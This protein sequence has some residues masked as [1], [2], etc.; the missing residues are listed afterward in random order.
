MGRASNEGALALDSEGGI[1]VRSR[2]CLQGQIPGRSILGN[3]SDASELIP[4]GCCYV[5]ECA[6]I[7]CCRNDYGSWQRREEDTT[8]WT[9]LVKIIGR[10]P[11]SWETNAEVK[12]IAESAPWHSWQQGYCFKLWNGRDVA[13]VTILRSQIF[14]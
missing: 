13:A 4:D 10:I 3:C 7:G 11:E 12:F 2:V 6:Y 1:G 5:L 8:A 9:V 14:E